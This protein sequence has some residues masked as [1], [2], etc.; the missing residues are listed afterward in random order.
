MLS[1]AST[2]D[3]ATLGAFISVLQ[4]LL[5]KLRLEEVRVP[6]KTTVRQCPA[7]DLSNILVQ[8]PLLPHS[9]FQESQAGSPS[10]LFPRG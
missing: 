3:R 6:L 7:L 10:Y 1:A 9:A 8:T 4:H 5:F 2:K